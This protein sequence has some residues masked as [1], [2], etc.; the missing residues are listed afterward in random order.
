ML[1]VHWMIKKIHP[2][3]LIFDQV[4]I[5]IP[6]GF[7]MREITQFLSGVSSRTRQEQSMCRLLQRKPRRNAIGQRLTRQHHPLASHRHGHN[8][9][10]LP[11]GLAIHFRCSWLLFHCLCLTIHVHRTTGK[12]SG[13]SCGCGCSAGTFL[14]DF[15]IVI[16]SHSKYLIALLF[17][18]V[19]M[20]TLTFTVAVGCVAASFAF[21]KSVRFCTAVA[22][23]GDDF[24]HFER[25][26][27]FMVKG[28]DY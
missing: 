6:V 15:N 13:C 12:G 23:F 19:P 3:L 1:V 4:V 10:P 7:L 14:L 21:P 9:P 28:I 11:H 5:I 25:M 17:V 8:L 27:I 24:C 20:R 2:F 26:N 18:F 22:A 16:V